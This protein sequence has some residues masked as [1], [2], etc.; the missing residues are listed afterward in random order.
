MNKE[1]LSHLMEK[2]WHVVLK[3]IA[4][5]CLERKILSIRLMV[6]RFIEFY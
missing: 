1:T 4:I 3:I 6:F 2:I 5:L